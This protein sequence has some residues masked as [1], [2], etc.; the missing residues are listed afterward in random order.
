MRLPE[1]A[2]A[3]IRRQLD[4]PEVPEADKEKRPSSA[5]AAAGNRHAERR[6][7]RWR[8]LADVPVGRYGMVDGALRTVQ[9]HDLSA[10]GVCIVTS[11][12]FAVGDRFV[13]YLPWSHEE[14][15]PL[16]CVVKTARVRSDGR[17]RVGAAFMESSDPNLRQRGHVQS[18]NALMGESRDGEWAR[19]SRNPHMPVASKTPRLHARRTAAAA[20]TLYTYGDGDVRGPQET[21]QARDYSDGG[22]AILRGEPLAVG[23]RFE[24]NLPLPDSEPVNKLCRVVHV[25]LSNNCYLI[26]A[27]FIPFPNEKPEKAR[28]DRELTKRIRRWLGLEAVGAKA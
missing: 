1:H 23:S 12:Q 5:Q 15:V 24:I 7:P 14:H 20:A 4:L 18:A 13:I 6:E 3:R 17:F 2:F 9:L 27:Q 11:Q 22:I 28:G 16:V 8:L 21:V 25:T 19:I 10:V 26:G